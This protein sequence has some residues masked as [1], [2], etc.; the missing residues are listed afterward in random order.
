MDVWASMLQ[1]R[2]KE[3]KIFE[4]PCLEPQMAGGLADRVTKDGQDI[5]VSSFATYSYYYRQFI[6]HCTIDK[7][8]VKEGTEVILH[9][10]DFGNTS[11]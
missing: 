5:G 4:L 10:G 1:P 7:A 2:E 3:Y 11:I 9:W 6:S 8:Y